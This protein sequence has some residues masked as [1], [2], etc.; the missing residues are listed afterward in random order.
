MAIFSLSEEQVMIRDAAKRIAQE[1]LAP[2]SREMEQEKKL[3]PEVIAAL[4]QSGFFG[5]GIPESY[6]GLGNGL[7][8]RVLVTEQLA[9]GDL[10]SAVLFGQTSGL[11][12]KPILNFGTEDQ[13]TRFLRDMV[14]GNWFGCY[15]LSEAGAGSD[16]AALST[17]YVK[18][19]NG[20]LLSGEKMWIT[21]APISE[22]MVVFARK[23]GTRGNEGISAFIVQKSQSGNGQD[24]FVAGRPIDKES[25][26]ASQ[27]SPVT[28]QD[29]RV[30]LENLLGGTEWEGKGLQIAMHALQSG[31]IEVAAQAIGA[32]QFAVSYAVKYAG[33]RFQ[34]GRPIFENQAVSHPLACAQIELDHARLF[35][36]TVAQ[37][38]DSLGSNYLKSPEA[39]QLA[40]SAK[41]FATESAYRAA[42]AAKL[43]LGGYGNSGE[44][45]LGRIHRDLDVWRTFE[46]TN[47]I[48]LETV[49]KLLRQR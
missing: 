31:R 37:R 19:D 7:L 1:V 29:T 33:Q 49:A 13:K 45:P 14:K 40:S 18:S 34:F 44:Y 6:G 11:F 28:L 43:T 27:T 38:F 10:A 4:Q 23:Q 39:R 32:A 22:Y 8:E 46:G 3:R 17:Q 36:Y 2:V 42:D 20:F 24:G 26:H 41:Y 21:G 25:I 9:S 15:A 47:R 5:I 12:A 48:Q 16:P 30:P 35:V